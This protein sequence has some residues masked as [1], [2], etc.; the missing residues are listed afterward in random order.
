M[1][2]DT[3][4][5]EALGEEREKS[6]RLK[7]Q[8]ASRDLRIRILKLRSEGWRIFQVMVGIMVG[9]SLMSGFGYL[10]WKGINS[11]DTKECYIERG[12]K[13]V[14]VY[15]VYRK[16]EWGSDKSLGYST[17]LDKTKEIAKKQGC[18]LPSGV[19]KEKIND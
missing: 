18:W 15:M 9:L 16:V 6:K 19:H 13:Q 2:D 3:I 12:S 17:D 5:A 4:L 8:I 10:C 1:N 14:E 7:E 11:Y